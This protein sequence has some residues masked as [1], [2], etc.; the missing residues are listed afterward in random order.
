M[1]A[2]R[3]TVLVLLLSACALASPAPDDRPKPVAAVIFTISYP[4]PGETLPPNRLITGVWSDGTV[5]TSAN[6]ETGGAPYTSRKVEPAQVKKLAADLDDLKFFTDE[7]LNKQ[8]NRYPPDSSY[9]AVAA[10]FAEKRQRLALW[11]APATQPADADRFVQIFVKARALIDK[12]G[13][14]KG[15]PVEKVDDEIFS[16]GRK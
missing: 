10:A 15:E 14:A 11:R 6:R 7:K 8:P 12:L 3:A 1:N 2:I 9:T 13:D 5:I 4:R 16:V